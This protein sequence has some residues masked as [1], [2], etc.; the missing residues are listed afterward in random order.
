MS[1]IH[2]P[3]LLPQEPDDP[4][5]ELQFAFEPMQSISKELLFSFASGQRL[6]GYAPLENVAPFDGVYNI[7]GLLFVTFEDAVYQVDL[8]ATRYAFEIIKPYVPY[9][10]VPEQD[11]D[12]DQQ[13]QECR[14]RY[15]ASTRAW[16]LHHIDE[17]PTGQVP[18]KARVNRL[19]VQ[20]DGLL[21][22]EDVI[23]LEATTREFLQEQSNAASDNPATTRDTRSLF[24][25]L[26][27]TLLAEQ[28]TADISQAAIRT[29]FENMLSSPTANQL[30]QKLLRALGWFG[31][32]TGE[33]ADT[34]ISKQLIWAALM[35][36]LD[37]VAGQLQGFV[38]GYCT[39]DP[40]HWGLSYGHRRAQLRVHLK[41]RTWT[42]AE[43]NE[44]A[45]CLAAH[46]LTPAMPDFAVMHI[47]ETLKYGTVPW[48]NFTHGVA[49]AN[50]IDPIRSTPLTYEQL[51]QLALDLSQDATQD[52]ITLIAA[53]RLAPTLQ[54]A[55]AHDVLTRTPRREP[56]ALEITHA[57]TAL[58]EHISRVE[59]AVKAIAREMPDRLAM[60]NQVFADRFGF[61]ADSLKGQLMVPT[62]FGKRLE[63]SLRSL[64]FSPPEPS[65]SPA[66]RYTGRYTLLDVFMA[67]HM[68]N[69][70]DLFEPSLVGVQHRELRESSINRDL[71]R[72]EG[73]DMPALYEDAFDRYALDAKS[74]YPVLIEQTLST[75]PSRDRAAI[76]AGRV[77][78]YSL[79]LETG[80]TVQSEEE[81]DRQNSRGRFGFIV[82][83]EYHGDH[84]FYEVFPL[85][86]ALIRHTGRSTFPTAF[87]VEPRPPGSRNIHQKGKLLDLDWN[88]YAELVSPR[89]G[90]TSTVIPHL[91]ATF[92]PTG[93]NINYAP[94]ATMRLTRIAEYAA[95]QNLF[96]NEGLSRDYH[97]H[98]S[99]SEKIAKQY[100]PVLQSFEI[101]VPGLACARSL[102]TKEA[103]VLTCSLE[104]AG[105]L[106]YPVIRLLGGTV[107]F[108]TGT[109]KFGIRLVLPKFAGITASALKLTG[110]HI[111]Q[112]MNPKILI[113]LARTSLNARKSRQSFLMG[114]QALTQR[115]RLRFPTHQ[116]E[117]YTHVGSLFSSVNAR[118][119]RPP[120][121]S[122]QLARLGGV[123]NVPIRSLSTSTSS[124]R[125]GYHLIN[126]FTGLAYGPRLI[127]IKCGFKPPQRVNN[128]IGYPM[129][130]R[131]SVSA[132]LPRPVSGVKG[133]KIKTRKELD[134][135]LAKKGSLA[136]NLLDDI[137]AE[138]DE[139][140]DLYTY[141]QDDGTESLMVQDI[142]QQTYADL[143]TNGTVN[144]GKTYDYKVLNSWG[145]LKDEAAGVQRVSID[146][147]T[148]GRTNLVPARVQSAKQAIEEGVPLLPV[149][150]RRTGAG[151][152][153]VNGNHR[154]EAAKQLGLRDIPINVVD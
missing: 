17:L 37:P 90:K 40:H 103:A 49:L 4:L 22:D 152:V 100:P 153:V 23:T 74:S 60:A 65:N 134:E 31:G 94:L 52:E 146:R 64:V 9:A 7:E 18:A 85:T 29:V 69:G 84:F 95:A 63:L 150:V 132:L 27:H 118:S 93:E 55:Y 39:E 28:G 148:S 5:P 66:E 78:I 116:A 79:R 6:E 19:P 101:I 36:E 8:D 54:W 30:S 41:R 92:D 51:L 71:K 15:E 80:K 133:N 138:F 72:L 119:W 149:D 73:I 124:T 25:L 131:G 130:G 3:T 105:I 98:E 144:V 24:H 87:E 137:R 120:L 111:W 56:T 1:V 32:L 82:G 102:A 77:S 89:K 147:I 104:A 91:I 122:D 20:V 97:R 123:T 109:L 35:L 58:D 11:P 128:R 110:A 44:N 26:S 45:A 117:Q 43:P 14:L 12:L 96:F 142:G 42:D 143:F 59:A 86:G 33:E 68:K 57:V 70:V 126:P 129:S 81:Q 121:P 16:Q 2:P 47:P 67:G 10:P 127:K 34:H 107:K 61:S 99:H 75:M 106:L 13:L 46:I 21:R 112:G 114:V 38:A 140:A 113:T 135:A 53:T 108:L 50:A 88:P 154:V 145:T 125:V 115:Y 136:G 83:C 76:N 141:K 62:S 151:Y 48:V 139:G